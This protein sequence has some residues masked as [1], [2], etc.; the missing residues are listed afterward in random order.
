VGLGERRPQF[1][2]PRPR[3][4]RV[5]AP[6]LAIERR[7]QARVGLGEVGL[8]L[9]RP[10]D[11]FQSLV[12]AAGQCREH[13]PEVAVKLRRIRP[14]GKRP[15]QQLDR[16]RRLPLLV[17]EEAQ[18]VEGLGMLRLEREGSVVR[19]LGVS[20]F[21]CAVEPL[22]VIQCFGRRAVFVTCRCGNLPSARL[23]GVGQQV[24]L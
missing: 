8:Q 21:V 2:R 11:Q 17:L 5:L 6:A 20:Q 12:R 4:P 13:A 24:W 15:G 23:L 3:R 22:R 19:R 7:G 9:D 14:Q 16:R 10:G 18:E 1:D